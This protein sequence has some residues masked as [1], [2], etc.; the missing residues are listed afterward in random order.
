MM[1]PCEESD[2]KTSILGVRHRLRCEY[3]LQID[4]LAIDNQTEIN[5]DVQ[6]VSMA[7]ACMSN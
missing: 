2:D 1:T 7:L 5:N 4:Q 6:S 3:D